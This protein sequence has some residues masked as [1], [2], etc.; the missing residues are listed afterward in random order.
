M[1]KTLNNPLLGNPVLKKA[2]I[3]TTDKGIRILSPTEYELLASQ[4]SEEDKVIAGALLFSGCRFTEGLRIQTFYEWFDGTSLSLPGMKR[5]CKQRERKI[6]LSLMGIP[7]LQKFVVLDKTIPSR[8]VWYKTLNKAAVSSRIGTEGV[9]NAMLR[10]T[11]E[12]WLLISFPNKMNE[13]RVSQ[14]HY[15]NLLLNPLKEAIK[16]SNMSE[17]DIQKIKKYTAGWI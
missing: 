13:I 15:S 9:C 12:Y 14:G 16:E 7:A 1:K 8:K 6:R 3:S 17:L 5:G 11:W 10:R 2:E 4:L